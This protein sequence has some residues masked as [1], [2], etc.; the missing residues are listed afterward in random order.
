MDLSTEKFREAKC[1]GVFPREREVDLSM[2]F[3]TVGA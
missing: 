2:T 1:D 3:M